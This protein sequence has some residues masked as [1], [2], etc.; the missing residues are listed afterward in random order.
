MRVAVMFSGGKDSTFAV[1]WAYLHGFEVAILLSVLPVRGDSW[2]FHRP[3]VVYTEL[4]AEAMGFRHMLVRVS[5]VKERE[6]EELAR[7]LRVVRDEFGVEGI[8]L[9]ALLSDY[10]RMRVALVSEEL[11]LKMFVPQWGV[12]QAE[13][14]RMLA[15]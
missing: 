15:R 1:H 10:Q 6:V 11:G 13:Y 3:M 9:G 5:G 12:N 8:V 2:M 14:M 4:Q 7:V